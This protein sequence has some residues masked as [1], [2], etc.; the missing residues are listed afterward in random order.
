MENENFYGNFIHKIGIPSSSQ[1][2]L[3]MT[4]CFSP[5]HEYRTNSPNIL[6]IYP[7]SPIFPFPSFP[8]I[9]V[10]SLALSEDQILS[11]KELQMWREQQIRPHPAEKSCLSAKKNIYTTTRNKEHKYST[12]VAY[13]THSSFEKIK[14][15]NRRKELS[16]PN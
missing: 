10:A 9:L 16:L 1:T 11:K 8:A 4:R 3:R 12:F 6:L 15:K 7:N 13:S 2:S 14:T 5:N